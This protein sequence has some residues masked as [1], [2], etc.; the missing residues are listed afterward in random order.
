MC[1]GKVELHYRD[2]VDYTPGLNDTLDATDVGELTLCICIYAMLCMQAAL[3][4][5]QIM[6]RYKTLLP[7][8]T[9]GYGYTCQHNNQQWP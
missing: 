2:C 3:F 4:H 8:N 5:T 6:L 9:Y 1:I 7:T